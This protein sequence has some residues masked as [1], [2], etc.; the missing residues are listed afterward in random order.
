MVS[1]ALKVPHHGYT[2]DSIRLYRYT[3]DSIRLYRYTKVFCVLGCIISG[4]KEG[5]SNEIRGASC[6]GFEGLLRLR[7]G[8][9]SGH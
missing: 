8:G 5:N 9:L 6:F 4:F 3:N 2:N 7:F 1:S